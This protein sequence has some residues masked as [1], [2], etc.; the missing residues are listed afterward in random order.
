MGIFDRLT[1]FFNKYGG[2]NGTAS[3]SNYNSNSYGASMGGSGY[4]SY[5]YS[6]N[7]VSAR[8]Y[9]SPSIADNKN[10]EVTGSTQRDFRGGRINRNNAA[11]YDLP[12]GNGSVYTANYDAGMGFIDS[13]KVVKNGP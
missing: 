6:G 4:S 7:G 9:T 13:N 3:Q 2:R 1:N 5:S 12:S 11:M 10:Y 8:N